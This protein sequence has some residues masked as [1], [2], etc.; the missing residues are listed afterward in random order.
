[1][2][3]SIL[4]FFV[5]SVNLFIVLVF[6]V[7]LGYFPS[8]CNATEYYVGTFGSDDNSGSS[9]ESPWKTLNKANQE[10][11]PGDI[12][13]V[14]PGEY[15]GSI[16]PKK[17]GTKALPI[18]FKADQRRSAVLLGGNDSVSGFSIFLEVDYVV[19]EGFTVK[20]G[21]D[22]GRWFKANRANYITV[23][24]CLMEKA[25]GS[26]PFEVKY[27]SH[28]NIR[29]TVLREYEG[30]NMAIFNNSSHILLEGNAFSRAGH[31]PIQFYPDGSVTK[32]V[33]RGNVFHATWGRNFEFFGV[34]YVLF[35]NN[36][37][38][39]AYNGGKSADSMAKFL[40]DY[41][42]FR[43][44]LIYANWGIPLQS[45][46][47]R[48]TIKFERS[49]LY[50]NVFH[51]N[52]GPGYFIAGLNDG[53]INDVIFANNVFTE[54]N[55]FGDN[56]QIRLD[57]GEKI[58]VKFLNNF[59]DGLVAFD[60][61]S[62]VYESKSLSEVEK[63]HP[64]KFSGNSEVIPKF[65]DVDN[66]CYLLNDGSP[67]KDKGRFLTAAVSDG[68]G[69]QI[70]IKDSKYF[71]DGFDIEGEL[72][73]LI[74]VGS[75]KNLAR[76]VSIDHTTNTMTLDRD[77]VWK[78]GDSVSLPW[79]GLAPDIGAYEYASTAPM[80]NVKIN[81]ARVELG[82]RINMQVET[83]GINVSEVKWY[84]GDGTVFL[85]S[86]LTKIYSKRTDYPIRVS[87]TDTSGH[88]YYGVGYVVVLPFENS[89]KGVHSTFGNDD[90]EWWWKWQVY[91]PDPTAYEIVSDGMT[92]GGGALHVYAPSTGNAILPARI[93]AGDWFIDE[94]SEIFLRYKV[95][96]NIP[97]AIYL[98]SYDYSDPKG[99]RAC[100]A[101]TS[102]A[103]ILANE[104]V[105]NCNI[106]TDDEQWHELTIDV[107]IVKGKFADL[108][109]L[110]GVRIEA[111]E[112][113]KISV[114][115]GYWLDEFEIRAKNNI[116]SQPQLL[117]FVE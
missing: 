77:I 24:D 7:F 56:Q 12:I 91:R 59:I 13:F 29:N 62:G 58:G 52:N 3:N 14:L 36:I 33:V 60:G 89:V 107:N 85:G 69:N 82:Q 47:Y 39:N 114:G 93:Y 64:E 94:Y 51:S 88:V 44:N 98:L 78:S 18:V 96:K 35:E 110:Q 22:D 99:L 101:K 87:V 61:H 115:Q 102:S 111:T 41:G 66:F 74:A 10:A 15:S 43:N 21:S 73:D 67:Q 23:N 26:E 97:L 83:F 70:S 109:L 45:S 104:S 106:L 27:C 16:S 25:K 112:A 19:V 5:C 46:P 17:S 57:N 105:D 1:M 117:R 54:N 65:E 95:N 84:L 116:P 11:N 9:R 40:V 4:E 38:T 100:V 2:K 72:G 108:K 6:V 34:P 31:A 90:P 81:P 68:T 49:R 80:V 30:H 92:D 55:K 75:V 76:V 37:I 86:N 71:Y 42:I 63:L 20:P 32:V 28:V 48:E 103:N 8:E 79:A 113:E 50:N 53:Y